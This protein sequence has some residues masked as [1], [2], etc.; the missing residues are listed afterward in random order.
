M[1]LELPATLLMLVFLV[2][3][4]PRGCVWNVFA[5]ESGRSTHTPF[6]PTWVRLELPTQTRRLR[7]T[8][9]FNPT[10]VRLE[11]MFYG[12]STTRWLGFQS[13]VGASGTFTRARTGQKLNFQSHV[14]ASGT[15]LSS[16]PN[17]LFASF[18]SHVGASGTFTTGWTGEMTK[19]FQ[20][21]VGAS[22]TAIIATVR[23]AGGILSIP[24]GCVWNYHRNR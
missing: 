3:S 9:S 6:N 20:S 16:V 10:W 1:R 19:N 8:Q 11:P 5:R 21:H 18:Q 13:H 14:G 15:G 23:P 2:L 22:G 4:I 12:A 7:G 17:S 24:R